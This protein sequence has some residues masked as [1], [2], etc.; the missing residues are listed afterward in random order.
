[1][2]TMTI[3]YFFLTIKR[4]S[5]I[6]FL[7]LALLFIVF[8]FIVDIYFYT[9]L[10]FVY[11]VVLSIFYLSRTFLYTYLGVNLV[12]IFTFGYLHTSHYI[13][14]MLIFGFLAFLAVITHFLYTQQRSY[15]DEQKHLEGEIRQLKRLNI[16]AEQA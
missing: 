8:S 5:F 9:Y 14:G 1:M 13:E 6:L 7:L 4:H 10:L 15:I 2:S 11:L 12:I 3:F 16:S